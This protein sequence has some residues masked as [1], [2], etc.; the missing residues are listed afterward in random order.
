MAIQAKIKT[1]QICCYTFDNKTR[2]WRFLI[3]EHLKN[4]FIKLNNIVKTAKTD[5]S[6]ARMNLARRMKF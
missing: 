3:T 2:T 1:L 4:Y 6:L 5:L